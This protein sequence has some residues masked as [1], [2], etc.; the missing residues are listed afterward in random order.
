M[1]YPLL[2]LLCSK[3]SLPCYVCSYLALLKY[4]I[5][6][7]HGNSKFGAYEV[8]VGEI[9]DATFSACLLFI[10]VLDLVDSYLGPPVCIQPPTL[11]PDVFG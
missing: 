8:T 1:D 11:I 2:P 7:S 3:N 4:T 10:L 5:L 9:P 6:I